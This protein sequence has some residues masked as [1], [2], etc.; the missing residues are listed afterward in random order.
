VDYNGETGCENLLI[1]DRAALGIG[2]R[3]C[4]QKSCR[5]R[6]GLHSLGLQYICLQYVCVV[7]LQRCLSIG[8]ADLLVSKLLA[9][10]AFQESASELQENVVVRRSPDAVRCNIAIV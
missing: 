7:R 6:Y 1:R 9:L 3:N 8:I 10:V 4:D 2:P 5:H